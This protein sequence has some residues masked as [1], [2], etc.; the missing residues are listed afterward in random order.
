[1][2]EERE[3]M[4]GSTLRADHRTDAEIFSEA[5]RALDGDAAVPAT[6]RVHV[7]AGILTLTGTVR[8]AAESARAEAIVRQV[9]GI[10]RVINDV[11]VSDR[12]NEEGDEPP[13]IPR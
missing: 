8:R 10:E 9:P 6:V 11:N 7:E 1:M 12:P 3:I 5:R 2:M 13:D 4:S